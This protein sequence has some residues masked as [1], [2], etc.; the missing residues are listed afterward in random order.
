MASWPLW[1][2]HDYFALPHRRVTT[3]GTSCVRPKREHS[4]TFLAEKKAQPRRV[5]LRFHQ[6]RR[7]W[8]ICRCSREHPTRHHYA[9]GDDLP[10][11]F[12]A[13]LHQNIYRPKVRKTKSIWP[14][15]SWR[16]G[17]GR[18]LPTSLD[19]GTGLSARPARALWRRSKPSASRCPEAR[20]QVLCAHGKSSGSSRSSSHPRS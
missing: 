12:F 4:L 8:R 15:S 18:A 3:W 20:R 5:A 13:A 14:A 10:Q 1:A 19:R 16:I 11:A 17:T 2:K 9:N 7:F 6:R